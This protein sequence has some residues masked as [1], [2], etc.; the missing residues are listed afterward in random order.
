MKTVWI[1]AVRGIRTHLGRFMAILLIVTL[2]AGFFAGFRITT[3]AMLATGEGYIDDQNFYDF[4]LFST[5]G[6]DKSDAEAFEKLSG[7]EMAEGSYSVDALIR[8]QDQVSTYKLH[9]LTEKTNLVSLEAGRMPAAKN[10]CLADP[11]RYT[12]ADIGKTVTV[13]QENKDDVKSQ[14]AETEFTIVGLCNSPLYLGLDRGSTNIG[15]GSVAGFIYIPAE[16]FSVDVFTEINLTLAQKEEIYSDAYEELVKSHKDEITLLAEDL[17][18]KRFAEILAQMQLTEEMAEQLGIQAPS[19]YVL[20]RNENAGY[21]SFENDTSIVS[22]VAVIFPVF[23]IAIAI[24]VCVTTMSR[25]VDEERT[26]IGT[27]KAMGFSNGAIVGKYLIYAAIATVLGWTIGYFLCI[28]GLPKIFWI[29]YGGI[30]KFAPIQYVF[31]APLAVVTLAISLVSILGAVYIA[32]RRALSEVPASLIRPRAGKVGKRVFLEHIKP[33]WNRLSFL[34]KIT[35]RNMLLYK[36]RVIMMLVGIGCCAGLLVTAFGIYDSMVG[37]G[38]IQFNEIQKY[39]MEASYDTDCKAS[40]NEKLAKLEELNRY[41]NVRMDK[42]EA[43]GETAMPSVNMI[44]YDSEEITEFWRLWK[45]GS[46]LA[47]PKKGEALISPKVAEKLSLSPGDTFALRDV[48]GKTVTVR[49]A[50]VFDNHFMDYVFLSSETY[51]ELFGAWSSNSLLIE[52]DGDSE[53]VATKLTGIPGITGVNQ[54]ETVEDYVC[55][56]LDCLNYIIALAVAFSAALAFIV[57]F[58][59]TN[60]NIAE[61][62]REIAT[63]QVLGFYPK[64]T[65]SY[66]LKENVIL[67][68]MASF[69]GLPLGKLFHMV[70]MGMA[71]IDAVTFDNVIKPQSYLLGFVTSVL[72]AVIVNHFMKRQITKVNMAESLKAVE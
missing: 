52:T 31:S 23:F 3:R 49:V 62:R 51:G 45:D 57:I 27:L 55:E 67:S 20:T 58:N 5:I 64:E 66:V 34:R 13:A 65:Q 12:E 37:V 10:E 42:V 39:N 7:I 28:W 36:S 68:F 30:Y 53:E 47:L 18:E 72:F 60:I 40:V 1:M 15:S 26:Q 69:L 9:A 17:A 63:V 59:L 24:L 8:F 22:S 61:R 70:V 25:M 29:P 43:S 50:A 19:V 48:G 44:S 41:M 16:A 33:L 6:F 2:S 32:C 11:V 38:D 56:A 4:R 14:L 21:V 71:K 54:L 46:E 35:T